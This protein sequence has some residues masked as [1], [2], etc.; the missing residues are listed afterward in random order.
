MSPTIDFIWKV[1]DLQV[2]WEPSLNGGG[3]VFGIDYFNVIP[4]RYPDRKFSNIM[5]WCAGPGFV[6]FGLLALGLCEKLTLLECNQDAIDCLEK[7][8][9]FNTQYTDKIE[10][11]HAD[12]V[13]AIPEKTKFDLIVGNPPHFKNSDWRLFPRHD[14]SRKTKETVLRLGVDKGWKIH[15]E[16]FE[17]IHKNLTDD[18]IIL[19]QETISSNSEKPLKEIA[20]VNNHVVTDSFVSEIA[21]FIYFLEIKNDII[22]GNEDA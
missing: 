19:L 14:R 22:M 3:T 2:F 15:T 13:N 11:I 17:N 9:Q 4:N 21:E 20:T 8:K 12:N 18:A 6:G 5:E 7:T 1:N 16:F 10:I